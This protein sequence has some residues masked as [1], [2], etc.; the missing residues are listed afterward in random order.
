MAPAFRELATQMEGVAKFGAI[1]C[2]DYRQTCGQLGIT[3]YPTLLLF[4]PGGSRYRLNGEDV[5]RSEPKYKLARDVDTM[6]DYV[7]K[8]AKININLLG[9]NV[10]AD[11]KKPTIYIGNLLN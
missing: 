8:F 4:A 11:T 7:L 9:S 1:S 3:G 6:R 10:K 2:R 5:R